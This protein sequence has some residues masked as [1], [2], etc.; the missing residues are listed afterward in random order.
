RGF[1][2]PKPLAGGG[3]EIRTQ[4]C[5]QHYSYMGLQGTGKTRHH[6]IHHLSH[7]IRRVETAQNGYQHD[8]P[9]ADN[10]IN[11][12]TVEALAG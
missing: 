6:L 3:Y 4:T 8:T 2:T 7:V 12:N 9:Q 5:S 10:G 11:Q 1:G